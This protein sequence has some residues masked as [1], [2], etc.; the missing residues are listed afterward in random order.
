MARRRRMNCPACQSP[1]D[2]DLIRSEIARMCQAK[3][4]TH[5]GRAPVLKPCLHCG[6]MFGVRAMREHKRTCMAVTIP[7]VD[8]HPNVRS[9]SRF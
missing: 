2:P 8:G 7:H 9:K 5:R 1:I 6:L 4:K 3:R